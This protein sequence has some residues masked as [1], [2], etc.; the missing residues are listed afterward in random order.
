M[1]PDGWPDHLIERKGYYSWR[2]PRTKKEHGLGRDEA[3][4]VKQ[5]N[6]AN[7]FIRNRLTE[8]LAEPERTLGDFIPTFRERMEASA[9]SLA[10]EARP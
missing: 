4:A 6:E 8:R 7:D 5:A 9:A 1:R 10:Q 3:E 2:D